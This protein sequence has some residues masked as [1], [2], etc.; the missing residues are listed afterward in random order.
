MNNCASDGLFRN[1]PD[2]EAAAHTRLN[3]RLYRRV[4]SESTDPGYDDTPVI[5]LTESLWR[6]DAEVIGL[7]P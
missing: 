4:L 2:G 5:E 7:V 6:V 3:C 1:E